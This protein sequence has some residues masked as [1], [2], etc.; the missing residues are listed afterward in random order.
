VIAASLVLLAL[1]PAGEFIMGSESGRASE[2]PLRRVRVAAFEMGVT[3]VTVRQFR[4]FTTATGYR[5]NAEREGWCFVRDPGQRGRKAWRI[6]RADWR[7]PGFP[8]SEDDPVVCISWEDAMAFCDWLSK[9]TGRRF[10]L[11][12]EAEWEYAAQSAPAL[13]DSAWFDANSGSRTHPVA[14]KKPNR[15]GMYDMQGNAWEWTAD[16]WHGNYAGAPADGRAWVDGG[17]R[18]VAL[19]SERDWRVL[20]GGAWSLGVSDGYGNVLR[21]TARPPF[22]KDSRCNNSGFRVAVSGNESAMVYPQTTS[23]APLAVLLL[24][25]G[26][27]GLHLWK[28]RPGFAPRRAVVVVPIVAAWCALLYA[29]WPR[30]MLGML[31]PQMVVWLT[32]AIVL[33]GTAFVF[34]QRVPDSGRVAPASL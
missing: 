34:G 28:R 21:V 2:R 8:Q 32:G 30:Y 10:R 7:R 29:P 25:Y 13:E 12:S 9:E 18:W 15:W 33:W 27:L 20:R 5:T 26:G 23:V 6:G 24:L 3:E 16:V 4:A 31:F 14:R 22:P 19:T 11:P 1:V 17:D